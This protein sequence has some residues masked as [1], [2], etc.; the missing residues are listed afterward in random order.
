MKP[1]PHAARR[2][3]AKSQR[4]GLQADNPGRTVFAVPIS[5]K[6]LNPNW[7][8]RVR[9]KPNPPDFFV[10]LRRSYILTPLGPR[11]G[12]ISLYDG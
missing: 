7:S 3:A 5:I 11:L 2:Q 8:V 9:M 10:S 4:N 12:G 1:M 6:C